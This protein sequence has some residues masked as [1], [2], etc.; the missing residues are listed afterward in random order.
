MDEF[1]RNPNLIQNKYVITYMKRTNTLRIV[2][3]P[4]N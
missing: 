1:N 3:G 4:K 2:M